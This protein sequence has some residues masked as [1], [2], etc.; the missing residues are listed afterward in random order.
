[1]AKSA[2]IHPPSDRHFSFSY[3]SVITYLT[4][5]LVPKFQFLPENQASG[6]NNSSPQNPGISID[7]RHIADREMFLSALEY[8]CR[9]LKVLSPVYLC[10]LDRAG[11]SCPGGLA[12]AGCSCPCWMPLLGVLTLAGC[13]CPGGL[14]LAGCSCPGGLALAGCSCSCPGGLALAGCSCSCPGG[15]ALAGCSCP[16][17]VLLPRG[18]C[19]C[20]VFLPRGPCPCWVFLLLS[21]GS[22]PCWVLLPLLG[23]LAQGVLP[24]LGALAQ[25][26]LPLPID[27][28]QN[29][30]GQAG[31]CL[32]S[33][34]M[35][36]QTNQ[37][38]T[39][40]HTH[41]HTH[42]HTHT[43]MR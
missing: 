19:P 22:C 5:G 24:L 12:L 42:A 43:Q 17:W 40:T 33:Y 3:F 41:T 34:T 8:L 7:N 23:A 37:H 29:H 16:C 6:K 1:M 20:W 39:H 27:F 32:P 28:V 9:L 25:G 15:L 30:K 14:A 21:R 26:A 13:S 18:S 11:C 10:P 31:L 2:P 4:F 35:H 38:T 36:V